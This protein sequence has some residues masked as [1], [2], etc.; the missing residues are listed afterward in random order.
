[1]SRSSLYLN[2]VSNRLAASSPRASVLGMY[3]GTAVSELVDPIDKRMNFSSEELKSTEGQ[4]FLGLTKLQDRLGSME[5]VKNDI[6]V[7]E[8]EEAREKT[9][10]VQQIKPHSSSNRA[11]MGSK[12]ISISEVESESETDDLPKYAKPD[13]DAS[14][15]DEDPTVI[16]RDKPSAPV[17]VTTSEF[18]LLSPRILI[19][20][21]AT[22]TTS[23]P[24]SATQKTTTATSSPSLTPPLSSAAKPPSA[25]RSPTT[26]KS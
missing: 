9:S 8:K 10:A 12:I 17:S 3:V 6:S 4:H 16:N 5:D 1:M 11:A 25:P 13:S 24:G 23:S 19:M 2:A 20:P 21:S 14:D 22:S 7:I 18:S 26:T 15:S